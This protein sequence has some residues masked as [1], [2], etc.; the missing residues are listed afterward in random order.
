MRNTVGEGGLRQGAPQHRAASQALSPRPAP[1]L[2]K[3]LPS[4]ACSTTQRRQVGNYQRP[5]NHRPAPP[6]RNHNSGLAP[7]ANTTIR[8]GAGPC[9]TAWTRLRARALRAKPAGST[10]ATP[11]AA[12]AGGTPASARAPHG[13]RVTPRRAA[14]Q[15]GGVN[16]PDLRVPVCGTGLMVRNNRFKV[17]RAT[18]PPGAVLRALR[19]PAP[20]V[21]LPARFPGAN[22]ASRSR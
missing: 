21:V 5:A 16:A 13:R 12:P 8:A 15:A 22:T 17:I 6:A 2:P 1:Q 4:S 14:F 10:S 18:G 9:G 7:S 20:R 11:G 3:T 19:A